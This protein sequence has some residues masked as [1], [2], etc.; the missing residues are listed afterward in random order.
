MK[1]VYISGKYT[2]PD[3]AGILENVKASLQ[4]GHSVAAWGAHPVIPHVACPQAST[5]DEAM[6]VCKVMLANCDW[7]LMTEG[8]TQSRGAMQ[9][10]CWAHESGQ[11]MFF[12]LEELSSALAEEARA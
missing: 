8:W 2:A 1:K 3:D 7:I 11:R 9:E 4:Y 12:S 5:W 10:L 6:A